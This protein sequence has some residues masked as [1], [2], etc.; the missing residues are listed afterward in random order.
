MQRKNNI[1]NANVT[2]FREIDLVKVLVSLN[3]IY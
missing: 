3:K 2:K 1:M